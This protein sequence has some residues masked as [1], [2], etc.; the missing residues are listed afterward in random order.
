M[1]PT[2]G[3]RVH[4]ASGETLQEEF[5][6]IA[7]QGFRSLQLAPTKSMGFKKE[8]LSP[9]YGAYLR[10]LL[11]EYNLRVAVLGSYFDLSAGGE[12][13]KEVQ[14]WYIAHLMLARW[15]GLSVIGTETGGIAADDP[16]YEEAFDNVINNLS[17]ILPHAEKFGI[18]LAIEPVYGHTIHGAEKMLKVLEHFPTQNLRVIYDP[19]NLLNPALESDRESMWSDFLEKLDNRLVAVHVKD[20]DIIDGKKKDLPAGQGRMDYAHIYKLVEKKP[21]I[22]LLIESAPDE[23]IPGIKE[24]FQF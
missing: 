20:Y 8:N 19:V 7:S 10:E 16:N 22:D 24:L 6:N 3:R 11:Q 2:W 12:E 13:A 14:E 18:C 21:R 23:Y 9:G 4:D 15:A 17:V 5:K 1:I